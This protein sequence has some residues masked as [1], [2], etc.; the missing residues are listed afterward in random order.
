[1][2]R[3]IVQWVGEW[4]KF[5]LCKL[6]A[7]ARRRHTGRLYF[8]KRCTGNTKQSIALLCFYCNAIFVLFF[9]FA[10]LLYTFFI[11]QPHLFIH[12]ITKLLS[13]PNALEYKRISRSTRHLGNPC[14]HA[15]E[16]DVFFLND[17]RPCQCEVSTSWEFESLA[18]SIYCQM[19]FLKLLDYKLDFNIIQLLP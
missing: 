15:L 7:L 19:C 5:T 11:A 12:V 2:G 14:Y 18:S 17:T 6:I 8:G 9:C 16:H 1:M 4:K 13:F 3:D 10:K